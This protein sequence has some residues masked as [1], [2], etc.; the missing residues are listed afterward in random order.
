MPK[1]MRWIVLVLLAVF[2][3]VTLVHRDDVGKWDRNRAAMVAPDEF[4]YLLMGQNFIQGQGLS[5]AHTI[6]RDT[7][8]PPG[9]PL[10]LASFG[11]I[12]G[13]NIFTA[14]VCTAFLLCL[15]VPV[16][17]FLARWM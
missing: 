8:Y 3:L 13:Y 15:C 14:H 17:Y 1:V 12:A 5:T 7:F 4:S 11:A 2:P 10:L 6:G 9:Y 16:V